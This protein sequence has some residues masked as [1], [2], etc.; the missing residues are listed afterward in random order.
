M[1]TIEASTVINASVAAVW[2][3]LQD[4]E[5]Y[6]EWNPF[7]VSVA[8]GLTAGTR[9]ILRIAA[10]G[11]RPMTFRPRVIDASPEVGLRWLGHLVVPGLC[12]ADHRIMLTPAADGVTTELV[13]RETFR[14]ILVPFLGGMME[15]TRKGF[16][17]MNA[18]LAE[19]VAGSDS[20]PVQMDSRHPDP[21]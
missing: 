8:G 20:H 7:I 21:R 3:V 9:P 15:P 19:R 12:D 11:K 16:Q 10:D 5:K 6:P 4:T 13:Q 1:R 14:G 2:E 17:A 18:A